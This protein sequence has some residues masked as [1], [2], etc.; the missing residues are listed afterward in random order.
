VEQCWS[1]KERFMK[2]AEH[3]Q[4]VAAYDHAR[5]VYRQ[6]LEECTTP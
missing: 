6:R 5:K 2:G 4:A 3:A 1:Q